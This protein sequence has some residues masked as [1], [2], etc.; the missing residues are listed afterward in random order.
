MRG[1][2]WASQAAVSLSASG[3]GSVSV[4]SRKASS[5]VASATRSWCAVIRCRASSEITALTVSSVPLMTI[6]SALLLGRRR[7]GELRQIAGGEGLRGSEGDGGGAAGSA[8]QAGRGVEGDDLPLVDHGDP[9]A[10]PLGLLHE[11][12]HEK[13]GH[14]TVPYLFDQSPGVTAG[15]W[16]ESGGQLVEHHD[17]RVADQGERDGQPLLLTAR[18]L[19]EP[20]GELGVQTESFGQGPPVGGVRMEGAVQLQRLA[21]RELGLQLAL[22]ELGSQQLRH[23]LVVGDGVESGDPDRAGV[24]DAQSLDAFDGGGLARAVGAEDPEDLPLVDGEAH[25]V[26]RGAPG[27]GL[28]HP[29]HFDDGHG[30]EG[31]A[32]RARAASSIALETAS[33]DRLMPGTTARKTR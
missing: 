17:P 31:P 4:R 27:V 7:S 3:S 26:H 22:L 15:P 13:D 28:A 8:D 32:G 9:V 11:V 18:Q 29:V 30:Y 1:R 20:G 5:K 6:R 16:V 12:G 14:A 24:G 10:E 21:H 19:G 33:A 23:R 2:W 25:S